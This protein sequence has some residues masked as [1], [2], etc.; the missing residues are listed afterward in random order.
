MQQSIK[1]KLPILVGVGLPLLLILWVV[2]F[3][4]ILPSIFIRPTHNFIYV[5]G[6]DNQ[7]NVYVE[8]GKIKAL[9]CSYDNNNYSY[10]NCNNYLKEAIY[11]YNVENNENILLS[12][13]EAQ[14]YN[15]DSSDKSSDG[16]IVKNSRDN[17]SDFYIFPFFFGSGVSQ[18]VYISSGSFSKQ[19]SLKNDRY[20]S[21]YDFKF[22]GWIKD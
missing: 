12:L 7:Q 15:L 1:Q 18:G 2:I 13:T 4:N 9:P 17:S 11:L 6:Y 10:R 14:Q 16:Y 21:Y 20:Y 3:V 22:L 5:T 19:I 8:D